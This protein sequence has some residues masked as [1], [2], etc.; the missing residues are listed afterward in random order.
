MT[1]QAKSFWDRHGLS[2]SRIVML[3]LRKEVGPQ[4]P[5]GVFRKHNGLLPL[6]D[7]SRIEVPSDLR[8]SERSWP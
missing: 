8:F 1:T 2:K 3:S 7:Q 5:V 4:V 6:L